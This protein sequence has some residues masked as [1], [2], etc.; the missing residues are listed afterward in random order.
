MKRYR[1]AI[2]TGES[3]VFY[4]SVHHV[5]TSLNQVSDSA[6]KDSSLD[7]SGPLIQNIL[8]SSEWSSQFEVTRAAIVPDNREAIRDWV[9]LKSEKGEADWILTTGGTGFGARDC[10]PEV[11]L[12]ARSRNLDSTD[13]TVLVR[14]YRLSSKSLHPV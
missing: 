1:V 8:E 11:C 2:L 7:R 10:T 5:L 12:F 14:Q 13:N 9:K 6:A 4:P 3:V